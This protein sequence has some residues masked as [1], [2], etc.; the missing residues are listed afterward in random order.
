[1]FSLL[2]YIR[3]HNPDLWHPGLGGEKPMDVAYLTAIV[4]TPYFPSY[5]PW[6]AGGY[7]N[8]YYFG[9]VLVAT[10][11]H[12]TGIVPTVAYNLAVPTFFALT[13]GG[14]FSAAL[15]LAPSHGAAPA[16]RWFGVRR[17]AIVAACAGALFVTVLG[18]LGQA[19]LLW[20]GIRALSQIDPSTGGPLTPLAQFADGLGKWRDGASL[21]FR[22]EWWYW[23]ATRI[24]PPGKDEVGPINE[25]PFFTFLFADLHAHML[26]L[27]YTLLVLGLGINIV[28]GRHAAPHAAWWR[29]GGELLTLGCAALA[30]GAL[31]PM[32]TWDVPTYTALTF[33]ALM[34]REQARRA[35]LT[36]EGLWAAVWRLGLILAGGRLLF[37]PFH[38][39]YAT[40]Y[41]GAERWQGSQTPLWAYLLIHG[42]FLFVLLSYL[43]LELMRGTGHNALTRSARLSL[44]YWR[45]HTRLQRLMARLVH[46]APG[47]RLAMLA[48]QAV[49]LLAAVLLA[50][51]PVV[52]VALLCGTLALVLALGRR[53]APRRQFALCLIGLGFALTGVV[54]LVVL[55]GDISRMNTV[56]K[57]YLQVW[58]VWGVAAAAVLPWC[59]AELRRSRQRTA[60]AGISTGSQSR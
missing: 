34:C 35:R 31:W 53:I 14:A 26:A 32:N 12:I 41:V 10:L 18:N 11:I 22:T 5:D 51:R 54:E 52:G 59:A 49:T 45:R 15:N 1:F 27:P 58:V 16:A 13:A 3:Y 25:M 55:K 46:P 6:F 19:Q 56:F 39:H 33:A 44:V 50:V 60:P 21:N 43:A 23:N 8:Y 20:D 40:A 2:L 4:R 47:Y 30:L 28:R 24:I 7:M 42:F 38:Q 29:D 36:L 17:S 9:F 57:M 48:V 37:L